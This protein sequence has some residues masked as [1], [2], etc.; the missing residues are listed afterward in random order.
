MQMSYKKMRV[1]INKR[2]LKSLGLTGR[3]KVSSF[4]KSTLDKN[5]T[6]AELFEKRD[7]FERYV[8]LVVKKALRDE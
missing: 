3:E 2:K 8:L 5:M 1:E 6:V 4:F 7:E